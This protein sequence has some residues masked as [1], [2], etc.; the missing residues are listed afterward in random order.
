MPLQR[1]NRAVFSVVRE[2]GDKR[3]KSA[4]TIEWTSRTSEVH[5]DDEASEVAWSLFRAMHPTAASYEN[6]TLIECDVRTLSS[7]Q[8]LV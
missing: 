3:F 2:V 6:T 1:H 8:V 5:D 7:R 4:T